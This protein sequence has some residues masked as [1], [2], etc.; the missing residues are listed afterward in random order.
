[1][2]CG[3]GVELG[4]VKQRADFLFFSLFEKDVTHF[5]S[6]RTLHGDFHGATV[7]PL[8]A[9]GSFYKPILISLEAEKHDCY[10]TGIVLIVG[11]IAKLSVA[12]AEE[13]AIRSNL[14]DERSSF[15]Q[16][17]LKF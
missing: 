14:N 17:R 6:E 2:R 7:A 13:I 15:P 9:K 11:T 12:V 3:L 10:L 1:M 16:N 5:L 8:W 4:G